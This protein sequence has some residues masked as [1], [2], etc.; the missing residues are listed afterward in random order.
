[1]NYPVLFPR[2]AKS[3]VTQGL[4]VLSDVISC[5]VIEEINGEYSLELHY[6]Q[7]GIH[8]EEIELNAIIAVPNMD[9]AQQEWPWFTPANQE[10]RQAFRIYYI[11]ESKGMPLVVMANHISFDLKGYPV[12]PFEVDSLGNAVE[13]L[14]WH[15]AQHL[16]CPFEFYTD[17]SFSSN[18]KYVLPIPTVAHDVM[19][20]MEGSLIDRYHGEWVFNNFSCFFVQKRGK[21]RG[22]VIRYGKNLMTFDIE[23][24]NFE[25]YSHILGFAQYVTEDGTEKVKYGH[26]QTINDDIRPKQC[27][28]VDLSGAYEDTI[29]TKAQLDNYALKYAQNNAIDELQASYIIEWMNIDQDVSEIVCLGDT[30]K[31]Y[32]GTK[33]YTARVKRITW[34]VLLGQPISIEIGTAK[35]KYYDKVTVGEI[36]RAAQEQYKRANGIRDNEP[37]YGGVDVPTGVLRRGVDVPSWAYLP[38]SGITVPG[39]VYHRGVDAP[40]ALPNEKISSMF[41]E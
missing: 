10:F 9:L 6:P 13:A 20:G 30:V 12:E 29:P 37:L 33:I 31:I 40:K 24:N 41:G 36:R 32:R 2:A 17:G 8:A 15:A 38:H 26:I 39:A 18:K 3:F 34:D 14:G 16:G 1:M 25:Q 5:Q 35:R 4:G 19:M 27:Y 22:A 28:I 7:E 23:E 11:E 21:N